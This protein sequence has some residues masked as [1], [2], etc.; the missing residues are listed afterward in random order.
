M[1][2]GEHFKNNADYESQ[3]SAVF[4][5]M[6]KRKDPLI[7]ALN[8]RVLGSSP[9][10]STTF[11]HI[12]KYLNRSISQADAD[13]CMLGSSLG[14]STRIHHRA[15]SSATIEPSKSRIAG[16]REVSALERVLATLAD[17]CD[18]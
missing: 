16:G 1:D 9:S 10:A 8:Q 5:R 3:I 6:R 11:S 15:W 17:H 14:S 4:G 18:G 7:S 12:L 2:T 13:V